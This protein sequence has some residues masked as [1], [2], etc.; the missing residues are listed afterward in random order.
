MLPASVDGAD[1]NIL[2]DSGASRDF[3]D[4][5][6]AR[7]LSLNIQP[8]NPPINVALADGTKL[9]S[10]QQ[11]V[12]VPVSVYGVTFPRTFDL[13]S[14]K[15]LSAVFG[16]PWLT[17][18]N[19]DI[20]WKTS[21]L[22]VIIDDRRYNFHQAGYASS[23]PVDTAMATHD[24]MCDAQDS[25]DQLFTAHVVPAATA[26]A[27][28]ATYTHAM[29]LIVN[30]PLHANIGTENILLTYCVTPVRLTTDLH[31]MD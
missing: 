22:S 7:G 14:M 10:S 30:A 11:A 8:R 1:M 19:P 27:W 25:G 17:D 3:M 20:N 13:L 15:G 18:Y 28:R 29:M 9:I 16:R 26:E 31:H 21:T 24:D 2:I 6:L 23:T 4:P 5:E 12:D